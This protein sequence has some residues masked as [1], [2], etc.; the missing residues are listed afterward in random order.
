MRVHQAYVQDYMDVDEDLLR[1]QEE[2]HPS[3]LLNNAFKA[4]DTLPLKQKDAMI[5][6]YEGKREDFVGA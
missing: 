3:N 2:L 5:A 1:V 4:F 6:Q